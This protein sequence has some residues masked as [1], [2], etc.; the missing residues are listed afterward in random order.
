MVTGGSSFEAGARAGGRHLDDQP[1]ELG[2][3]DFAREH[4]LLEPALDLAGY[5]RSLV[6]SIKSKEDCHLT[7]INVDAIGEGT[8]IFPNKFQH[9]NFLGAGKEVQFPGPDAPFIPPSRI[10]EPRP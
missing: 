10:Q 2:F 1:L 9:D 4:A 6:F 3:E 5:E 8:V 7:L